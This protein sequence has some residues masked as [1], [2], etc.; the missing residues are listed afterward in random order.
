MTKSLR[1]TVPKDF[2]RVF[3]ISGKDYEG[4]Q[5]D[6]LDTE[7]LCHVFTSL[8]VA[9]QFEVAASVMGVGWAM[10]A[11][12]RVLTSRMLGAVTARF[13]PIPM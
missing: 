12:R 6:L 4:L 10:R 1:E 7:I 2:N 9:D 5:G 8:L 3:M 11:C 13:N